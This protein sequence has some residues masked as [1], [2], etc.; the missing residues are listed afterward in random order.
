CS[1]LFSVLWYSVYSSYVPFLSLHD[2][3]PIFERLLVGGPSHWVLR[4]VLVGQ[5]L[6]RVEPVVR[7]DL[8]GFLAQRHELVEGDTRREGLRRSEEHT[9]E[10]QSREKLVC[11]LLLEE[12]NL[13]Q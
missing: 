11:R 12:K 13:S 7:E 8:H 1:L 4:R 6:P 10:L 5:G 9:S 3:L 2:A